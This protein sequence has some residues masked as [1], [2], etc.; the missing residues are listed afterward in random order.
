MTVKKKKNFSPIYV[1]EG[2]EELLIKLGRIDEYDTIFIDKYFSKATSWLG[3]F[4]T[5]LKPDYYKEYMRMLKHLQQ[6]YPNGWWKYFKPNVE[7][8]YK[9]LKIKQF[10]A[11]TKY[12]LLK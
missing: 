11:K 4:D 9:T 3:K 10:L 1:V 2:I 5:D 7:D 12:M 8:S 6:K